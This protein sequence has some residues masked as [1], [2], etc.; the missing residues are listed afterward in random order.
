MMNLVFITFNIWS[1][2]SSYFE[3]RSIITQRES[4]QVSTFPKI[5]MCSYQMHSQKLGSKNK[6]DTTL[7]NLNPINGLTMVNRTQTNP[8]QSD[9]SRK[10][11]T[12]WKIS[13][14]KYDSQGSSNN[15]WDRV[16]KNNQWLSF[17]KN[18]W[19]GP[20]FSPQ[21]VLW[22]GNG[23][24]QKKRRLGRTQQNRFRTVL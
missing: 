12:Y 3:Y 11:K 9:D 13:D 10:E 1:S 14:G 18:S 4:G 16:S 5:T 7:S 19:W 21:G 23:A 8:E 6:C 17:I 20:G 22:Y 24:K 2:F 15:Q